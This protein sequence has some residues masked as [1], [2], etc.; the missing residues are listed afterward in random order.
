MTRYNYK[1]IDA[2]GAGQ[3]GDLDC[4][5]REAAWDVLHQRGLIPTELTQSEGGS[6][7]RRFRGRLSTLATKRNSFKLRDL[8]TMTQSLAALLNAG[9][10]VDRSLSIASQLAANADVGAHLGRLAKTV[11]AGQS[12]AAAFAASGIALP[13]YYLSLVQAGEVGGSLA[14]TLTRLGELVRKQLD[15]R[16]RI[17]S[18]LVYPTLLAGVV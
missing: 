9:L 13:A 11:R 16:E 5:S 18:A 3:S 14:R 10:T 17:R 4:A 6:S 12:L 8:V 15:V 1:A 7:L 2:N